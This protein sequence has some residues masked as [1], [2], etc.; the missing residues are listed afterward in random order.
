MYPTRNLAQSPLFRQHTQHWPVE[1]RIKRSY[2][3]S[4][5]VGKLY[6]TP[7]YNFLLFNCLNVRPRSE[8]L[9]AHDIVA[10]SPKF[11]QLHTD[12]IWGIDIAAA[13]L[14]MIQCNL[15]AGTIA[16]HARYNPMA[17]EALRRVLTFE[18]SLVFFITRSLWRVVEKPPFSGQFCL[19]EVAHGI[20]AIHLE[21]TAELMPDGTFRLNSP[22]EG[23]GKYVTYYLYTLLR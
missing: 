13:A 1:E 21:T 17:A 18:V 14:T 2:E 19:T 16:P 23:A 9:S 4:K 8:D 15:C 6:G 10:L 11:W 12:P 20:D 22:N 5:A 7:H 3:R